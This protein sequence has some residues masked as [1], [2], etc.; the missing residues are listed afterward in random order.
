[1]LMYICIYMGT[2]MIYAYTY[3]CICTHIHINIHAY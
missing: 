3:T 1:M 2:H